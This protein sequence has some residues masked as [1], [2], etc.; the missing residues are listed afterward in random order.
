MAFYLAN[1]DQ[2]TRELML[3]EI[4]LD[5]E[6]GT[7]YYG[8]YLSEQGRTDYAELL[9]LAATSGDVSSLEAALRADGRMA[10]TTQR[11]KPKGGFST[12]KVPIT[13]P[14]TLAEGEFNR[15]YM[16][17]LCCRAIEDGITG[18]IV[19][20]AKPVQTPRPESEA[21]ISTSVA[22][23]ALLEDL[24]TSTGVDTALGLPRGPNSGLSARL[25]EENGQTEQ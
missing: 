10:L 14:A 21:M 24:R 17:A 15:F 13:A 7:L 25:P 18:L 12:V 9:R 19:Y 6:A 1:L 5:V 23:D 3:S 8:S 11:R 2:R 16:R 4:D 20:R 22:P